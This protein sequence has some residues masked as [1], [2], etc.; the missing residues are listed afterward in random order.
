LL[1][2]AITFLILFSL[3]KKYAFGPI[4]KMLD[5]RRQ[6][7]DDGVRLGREMEKEKSELDRQVSGQ[8]QEARKEADRIIASAHQEAGDVLRSA[9]E[10]ANDKARRIM[11][12]AKA[13]L[14]QDAKRTREG[15]LTET[16]RLVA[17]ATEAVIDE[18]LDAP[19]DARLIE[20]AVSGARR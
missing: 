3:L 20:R 16:L 14:D 1:L 8:L 2:Q 12:D 11:E 6:A 18:K 4:M 10:A 17:D 13:R 9:E 19:G 5:E 15:L 7:I